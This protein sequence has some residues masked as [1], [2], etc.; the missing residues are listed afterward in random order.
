MRKF[1]LVEAP[2][3]SWAHPGVSGEL[4]KRFGVLKGLKH[5]SVKAL[6]CL[7]VRSVLKNVSCWCSLGRR[8]SLR[9]DE[10]VKI[11]RLDLMK[12]RNLLNYF[13][14]Q[15]KSQKPQQGGGLWREQESILSSTRNVASDK[16]LDVGSV[17]SLP[18]P[19]VF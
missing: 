2:S 12:M 9:R 5:D 7:D 3:R 17:I 10:T 18:R 6:P 16:R 4:Y 8:A 15:K 1:E 14:R 19:K 11:E 13:E